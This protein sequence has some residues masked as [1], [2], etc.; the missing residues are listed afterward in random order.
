MKRLG[1][2]VGVTSI[3]WC[4]VEYDEK[5]APVGEKIIDLGARIFSDGRDPKSGTSLAVDRRAARGMRRRR[6]RYSGRRSAFL[7][8]LIRHGLMAAD[9][10][11][12]KLIAERDPY[13]LGHG[14]STNGSS[15]SKSGAHCFTSTS[16][17]GSSRTG[18]PSVGKRTTRAARSRRARKGWMPQCATTAHGRSGNS[19]LGAK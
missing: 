9:A 6:D 10:N 2:D 4:L 5:L 8:A 12:A 7:E 17:A 15:L 13:A 14:R 11:E 16:V 3:G 19:L 18:R 1:L